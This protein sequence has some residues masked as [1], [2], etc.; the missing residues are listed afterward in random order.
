MDNV[1]RTVLTESAHAPD[2][3]GSELLDT[4]PEAIFDDVVAFAAQVLDAPLAF[5]SLV[6]DERVWFKSRFGSKLDGLTRSTSFCGRTVQGNAPLIVPDARADLRF[7]DFPIVAGAPH[8]RFYA[9]VPVRG[10][11]GDVIGTLCVLGYS[12]RNFS[13]REIDTLAGFARELESRVASRADNAAQQQLLD[14]RA[15]LLNMVI[16]DARG[17]LGSMHWSLDALGALFPHRTPEALTQLRRTVDELQHLCHGVGMLGGKGPARVPVSPKSEDTRRWLELL[18]RRAMRLA[19]DSGLTVIVDNQLPSDPVVID[20]HLLDRILM[21][22]ISNACVACA[23]DK[24]S[25]LLIEAVQMFDGQLRFCVSDDGPGVPDE[26]A[27]KI[28]EAYF[29]A[30]ETGSRGSGLGLAFGRLAARAMGGSLE[31]RARDPH[32]AEFVL[33]VPAG[34]DPSSDV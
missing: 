22:L 15:I 5:F 18:G 10:P 7:T 21:N 14:E 17:L 6:D 11:G 27:D 23:D 19:A 1:S 26:L 32:G 29:T 13:A 24:G 8:V 30:R 28:F 3:A 4:L 20:P 34:S 2:S 16:H 12:P 9:G 25:S 33:T 31:Y